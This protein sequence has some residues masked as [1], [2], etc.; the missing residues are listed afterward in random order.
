MKWILNLV[1][2]QH[3]KP[4]GGIWKAFELNLG[5]GQIIKF[6]DFSSAGN[7]WS[8]ISGFNTWCILKTD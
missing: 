7:T 6:C 8:D 5:Q 1:I 2:I 3:I 4:P